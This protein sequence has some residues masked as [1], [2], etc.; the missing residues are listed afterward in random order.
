MGTLVAEQVS[1][2]VGE[3]RNHCKVRE[4]LLRLVS[5]D[6]GVASLDQQPCTRVVNRVVDID[7]YGDLLVSRQLANH[8]QFACRNSLEAIEET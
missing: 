5:Q 6:Q 8:N 2:T 3:E 7:A 4:F 1:Q